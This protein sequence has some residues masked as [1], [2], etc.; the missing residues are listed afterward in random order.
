MIYGFTGHRPPKLGGYGKEAQQKLY[1]FAH[2]TLRQKLKLCDPSVGYIGDEAIVGMA[3]GWDLQIATACRVLDVPYTAAVP[4]PGQELVWPS[5]ETRALYRSLL[6]TAERI[7]YV[8]SSTHGNALR[9]LQLRNQY[10]VD[11][12]EKIIAL[13]DEIEGWWYV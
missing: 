9:A 10:I 12:S 1:N 5:Q 6:E 4:Y 8:S 2:H 13:W 3:Q 11:H 7:V